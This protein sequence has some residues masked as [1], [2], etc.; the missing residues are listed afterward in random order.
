MT[1][2]AKLEA[3]RG[4]ARR[5]TGPRTAAGKAAVAANPIRHGIFARLPVVPGED[6]AAWDAHRAGILHALAPAGLLEVTFAERVALVL[7][8]LARL[9]RYEA[10][11][12]AAAVADAGLDVAAPIGMLLQPNADEVRVRLAR[13]EVRAAREG[14]EAVA[15]VAEFV[16]VLPMSPSETPVQTEL[17]NE[18]LSWACGCVRSAPLRQRES[19]HHTDAA[20]RERLGEV[21]GFVGS[22]PST[23]SGATDAWTVGRVARAVDIY[24]GA[25]GVTGAAFRATLLAELGDRVSSLGRELARLE[26]DADALE[27]RAEEGRGRAADANLLS[28]EGVAERVMK[29]E[30][31][32]HGMLTSTM[33]EL[34]RMQVRRGGGGVV[35]P[36]VADVNV[37]V[38]G[39]TA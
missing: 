24:A 20:F 34:E 29:Y 10:A 18:V 27:R 5:S 25:A 9:A 21:S 7:W 30:K 19:V 31:H 38:T 32:L 26:A 28:P 33:H 14:L 2:L 3:N 36:A 15:A 12:T 13:Q 39:G 17:A 16:R 6:P 22:A 1:T 4:N 11:T 37:T 23:T 35:P 8:R